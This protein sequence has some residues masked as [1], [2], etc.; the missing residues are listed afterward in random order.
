MG[1]VPTNVPLGRLPCEYF[2]RSV[3]GGFE[4]KGGQNVITMKNTIVATSTPNPSFIPSGAEWP[5]LKFKTHSSRI[6]VYSF[7]L[8]SSKY[9]GEGHDMFNNAKKYVS[10]MCSC[11]MSAVQLHWGLRK[12]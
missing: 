11:G 6:T 5:I 4:K 9:S 7:S 3:S 1:Y 2:S 8:L 12:I 10:F